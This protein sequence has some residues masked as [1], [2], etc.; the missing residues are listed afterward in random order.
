[1]APAN[2]RTPK[3]SLNTAKTHVTNAQGAIV[4]FYKSASSLKTEF[5]TEFKPVQRQIASIMKRYARQQRKFSKLRKAIHDNTI[6]GNPVSKSTIKELLT[7]LS[8]VDDV[9]AEFKTSLDNEQVTLK[10]MVDTAGKLAKAAEQARDNIKAT[11]QS[12]DEAQRHLGG[13]SKAARM[14]IA[15]TAGVVAHHPHS[16]SCAFHSA[17]ITE[18]PW[19]TLFPAT[20]K[21]ISTSRR[22][23]KKKPT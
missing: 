16:R 5:E 3:R 23:K 15:S 9:F 2:K 11:D 21:V 1:M 12:I 18:Y 22:R 6:Q 14:P 13:P 7:G 17:G 20:G 8:V 19:E 10:T 4:D